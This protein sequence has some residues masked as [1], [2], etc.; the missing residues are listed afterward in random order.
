MPVGG[1]LSKIKISP[2]IYIHFW[3]AI[4]H[5]KENDLLYD[6]M[7]KELYPNTNFRKYNI[8]KQFFTFNFLM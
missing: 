5:I 4:H 3:N 2:K 8:F 1:H 6:M 7:G